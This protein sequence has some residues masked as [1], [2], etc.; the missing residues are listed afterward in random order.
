[1]KKSLILSISLMF[2]FNAC[3]QKEN[4]EKSQ[5]Q[6]TEATSKKAIKF[7]N[8]EVITT[9]DINKIPVSKQEIGTFPYLSSPEG[10][11]Y[12]NEKSKNYEEKYFCF[13]DS[14][15]TKIGGKYFFSK[16]LK[17]EDNKNE[18]EKSF[19][20][21]SYENAIKKLGGIQIYE[22]VY[23]KKA[24]DLISKENPASFEDLNNDLSRKNIQ[25]V[26]KVASGN[27]WFELSIHDRD[28]E[29]FFTVIQEE[30]F[31]QTISILK[32]DEIKNQLD[33]TGKAILYIN[34]DTYKATLKDDGNT[35]VSEIAKVMQ[36]DINLKVSI[37]GHTD[38]TGDASHNKIL[39]TERA[40]T[41]FKKLV[42]LKIDAKRL[43]SIGY[44]AQKPLIA[45]DTEENK[46]KNRR[47]EIVKI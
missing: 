16:I 27:I 33:K 34:F 6:Q 32:A 3:N 47:V 22:G 26:L 17:K 2:L 20:I 25:F 24:Q 30:G 31:K 4:K 41:V 29:I 36:N 43:K 45:N 1:M 7:E 10:Y 18:Y 28:N 12:N 8:T 46:A 15:V 44:G 9:F 37:E 5:K 23:N 11:V 42:A 38:N 13:N 40:N 21:K 35:A 39:S 19:V 14:L